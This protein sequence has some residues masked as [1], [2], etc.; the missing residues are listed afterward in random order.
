MLPP[1]LGQVLAELARQMGWCS[2]RLNLHSEAGALEGTRSPH[3]HRVVRV[4][5]RK[6]IA[7]IEGDFV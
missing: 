4:T 6:V 3:C 2:R 7:Q 1:P 5:E